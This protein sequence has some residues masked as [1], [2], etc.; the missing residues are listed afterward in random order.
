MLGFRPLSGNSDAFP[1]NQTLARIY[2]RK[3]GYGRIY[4]AQRKTDEMTFVVKCYEL[5]T[6]LCYVF[7]FNNVN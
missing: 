1:M 7:W 4:K 6:Q 3:C 2:A 5:S